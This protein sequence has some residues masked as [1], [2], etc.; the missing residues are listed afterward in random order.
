[1]A[2]HCTRSEVVRAGMPIRV[3]SVTVLPIE[4]V[5]LDLNQSSGGAW[6]M[7]HKEPY[8]VIVRDALGTRAVNGD[9]MAVSLEELS[10]MV[11]G[12]D[13]LLATM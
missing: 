8:A 3:E 13:A 4:R 12:L 9:A 5:V 2:K 11:P 1:M 10:R 6:F 7:A